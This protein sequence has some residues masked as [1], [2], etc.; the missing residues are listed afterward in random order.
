MN[1]FSFW[2]L[3][4]LCLLEEIIL[5]LRLFGILPVNDILLITIIPVIMLFF[6]FYRR[7]KSKVE[8]DHK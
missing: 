8:N 1:K 4:V 5:L 6:G 3:F 2:V 7:S